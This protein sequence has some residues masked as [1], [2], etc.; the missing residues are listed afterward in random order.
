MIFNFYESASLY[1]EYTNRRRKMRRRQAAECDYGVGRSE[2]DE[3]ERN[4]SDDDGDSDDV[5]RPPAHSSSS[6]SSSDDDEE[7]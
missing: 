6:S 7:D 3:S 1:L 4:E 2:T 5:A